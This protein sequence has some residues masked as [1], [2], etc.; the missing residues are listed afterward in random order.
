MD[1]E[2]EVKQTLYQM[3][4]QTGNIPDA[5]NLT[6][7]LDVPQEDILDAFENLAAKR[8]LVLEPGDPSKIRMAPPFSGIKTPFRVELE[9]KS[10]YANCV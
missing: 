4:A 3:I 8:L 9:D 2:T 1:F 6:S 7:K 5:T 10:F